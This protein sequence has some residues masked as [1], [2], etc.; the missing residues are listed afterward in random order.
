MSKLLVDETSDFN[1]I[2][3]NCGL[4][5]GAHKAIDG[6]LFPKDF[7]PG[8]EGRMD[9]ENSPR[10]TFEAT[11]EFRKVRH[12]TKAKNLKVINNKKRKKETKNAYNKS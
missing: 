10:T 5:L 3:D 1:E 2:C 12:N 9:W 4:T 7:C 8:H 11:G 6:G